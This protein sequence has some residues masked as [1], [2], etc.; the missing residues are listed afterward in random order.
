M[1]AI[2]PCRAA[3]DL[4]SGDIAMK[5][6]FLTLI[7]VIICALPALISCA[8]EA[9]NLDDFE[10]LVIENTEAETF[11]E[12]VYVVIPRECSGELAKRAE[13][14]ASKIY[15]QTSVET[16][17][18]Y[19]SQPMA[20]TSGVLEILVGNTSRTVSQEAFR[21]FR[22]RDYICKYEHGVILLGGKSDAATLLAID[23]FES[24]ILPGA[25]GAALMSEHACF[26]E[27]GEYPIASLL[28][29][30]FGIYD[31]TIVYGEDG[32]ESDMAYA[33][34]EYISQRSGYTLDVHSYNGIDNSVVKT[35]W[36]RIDASFDGD[37]AVIESVGGNIEIYAQSSYG[38]SA[39]VA[40]FAN[41]LL[42]QNISGDHEANIYEKTFVDCR[43]ASLRIAIVSAD[44]KNGETADLL[45]GFANT[46]RAFDGELICF[47]SVADDLFDDIKSNC[48]EG[49]QLHLPAQG[50]A[51]I[52][53]KSVLSDK[54]NTS[55]ENHALRIELAVNDTAVWSIYRVDRSDSALA[56]D[57]SGLSLLACNEP[58]TNNGSLVKIGEFGGEEQPYYVYANEG[59]EAEFAVDHRLY[60]QGASYVSFCTVA[61][62]AKYHADFQALKDA[63]N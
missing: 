33:L 26:E 38:V 24:E 57:V 34:Q 4:I 63:L 44:H 7:L 54:L 22:D 10:K 23:R 53:C 62:T 36:I 19:D 8:K 42:P 55:Y 30:G 21:R 6:R 58:L 25:S 50:T 20:V 12:L 43:N 32:S 15:E 59:I 37:I 1:G 56:Q 9:T 14:L 13:D 17:V 3:R 45:I 29:N 47:L 40:C 5:R 61:M 28:L 18:K 35:I 11:A 52:I 60:G 41:T 39:A 49:H 51:P 31:Y 48:V 27:S 16:I 2:C 46:I